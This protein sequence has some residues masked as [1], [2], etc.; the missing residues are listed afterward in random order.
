[1]KAQERLSARM[2][3]DSPNG[4]RMKK[5]RVDDLAATREERGKARRDRLNKLRRPPAEDKG[6]KAEIT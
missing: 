4:E 6:Q 5:R 1:M 2:Q 3:T